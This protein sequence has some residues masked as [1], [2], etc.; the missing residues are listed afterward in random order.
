MF[1]GVTLE[2]DIDVVPEPITILG[3]GL[4]LASLPVLKKAQT[5]KISK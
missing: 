5:Q 4:V 3:T 1:S 2:S